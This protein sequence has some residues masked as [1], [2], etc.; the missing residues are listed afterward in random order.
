MKRHLPPFAAVRAFEA[1]AKH[2][3]FK[4]AAEEINLS[5][6]AV[7]HQVRSLED[8]LKV[9]LFRRENGSVKLTDKGSVYYH[10][11]VKIINDLEKATIEVSVQRNV[12][13]LVINLDHSLLSCWL[14]HSIQNFRE[15]YPEVEIEFV[16]T[17]QQPDFDIDFDFSIYFAQKP[18]SSEY[19][20]HL[21]DDFITLVAS[22]ELAKTLPS[23]PDINGLKTQTFLHCSCDETEWEKWFS[24][25]DQNAPLNMIKMTTNNR[26]VIL[27][28]AERGAGIAIGRQPFLE[29][30][31]E[32]KSLL[33]PYSESIATGHSYFLMVSKK[34]RNI[35][36][37]LD[38]VAWIQQQVSDLSQ[39]N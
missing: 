13:R 19:S 36:I 21:L 7:S 8:Y 16:I 9:S 18:I 11:I 28:S 26:A 6:S 4:K 10:Q 38:F 32:R 31:L 33:R 37:A 17:E 22:P 1:A 30:Y 39:I 29:P 20:F 27:N 35:P 2:E 25:L 3:N 5:A 24:S 14:E 23:Q 12:D 34:S 15:K